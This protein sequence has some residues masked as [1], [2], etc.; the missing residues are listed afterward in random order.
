MKIFIHLLLIT[1]SA[2][3]FSQGLILDSKE[4]SNSRQWEPKNEQGFSSSDLPSKISYR[5]YTP[6]IQDQGKVATCVG[7]S[8]AY[9]QLSTQQNLLMG[10][11]DPAQKI[12]RSMD[13]FFLYGHI[14]NY[15][16]KWC[17]NGTRIYDA[18]QIL[19]SKGTKPWI[20]DPWLTCNS[21]TTFS[22]FTNALSSNY[23]ISDFSAVPDDD[24][25]LNVKQALFYK[26]IV[27][28][29]I[30][31][32][33]SFQAGS[34]ANYGVWTPSS[35]E[36]PIGG[37]AMCVVGYD[38]TKYGGAFEVMNSWGA[39]YGENG[40]V[41]IKY[42]DFKKYVSE[43][44][45]LNAGDYKKGNC[46]KGDCYNSYSRYKYNDGSI[47]E[48]LIVNGYPDIYG[49]FIYKNG[50]FYVGGMKKGRKH[51]SGVFFDAAQGKYF[52]VV[53]NNDTYVQWSLKQGFASNEDADKMS[54]LID[55]LNSGN[56]ATIVK[57]NSEEQDE[58]FEKMDIPL[59]PLII[60]K[61]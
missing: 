36:K 24:L 21:K 11:T 5:R 14:K 15:N 33:E 3:T 57:P 59:E 2:Y 55:I 46:S 58:Y 27:S 48:G 25:V 49:S 38:D 9:A 20:W 43:A 16:D 29:G 42:S 6:A 30:N 31:L 12:C 7:W 47:Y 45:V 56:P 60:P 44:Y 40:F 37:H 61:N 4:Y 17:Q 18:M 13:P 32:T 50:N 52:N 22:E 35:T 23:V 26:L 1:V 10:I 28:V 39:S 8:V 34:A 53:F 19:M 51:G 41:W 54:K